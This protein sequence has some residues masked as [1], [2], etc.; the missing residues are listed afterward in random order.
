MYSFTWFCFF[1][2]VVLANGKYFRSF[3]T[4]SLVVYVCMKNY[5]NFYENEYVYQESENASFSNNI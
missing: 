1:A 5:N 3:L 2:V 4:D